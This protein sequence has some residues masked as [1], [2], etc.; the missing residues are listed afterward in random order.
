[1]DNM[2]IVLCVDVEK[3]TRRDHGNKGL[4]SEPFEPALFAEDEG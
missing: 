1:M 4:G 2:N 3:T